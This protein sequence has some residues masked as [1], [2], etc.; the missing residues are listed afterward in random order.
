MISTSTARLILTDDH[1]AMLRSLSGMLR[2][3]YEITGLAHGGDELLALLRTASADCLLLDLAMP[4]RT[5]IELL[6]EI[7]LAAPAMRVVILTMHTHPELIRAALRDGAHGFMPK[8]S[9]LD[10]LAEA[11]DAV[12]GGAMWVSPRLAGTY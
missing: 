3:R 11:I 10:E 7:R 4:G 2:T 8:D 1:D 5:G 6:P 9:G 12:L